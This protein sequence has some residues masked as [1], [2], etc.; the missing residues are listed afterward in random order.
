MTVEWRKAILGFTPVCTMAKELAVAKSFPTSL[1]STEPPVS[2]LHYNW[3]MFHL[4]WS[5]P[6]NVTSR[7]VRAESV[8]LIFHLR[9]FSESGT[10][11]P[12]PGWPDWEIENLRMRIILPWTVTIQCNGLRGTCCCW[13]YIVVRKDIRD[14]LATMKELFVSFRFIVKPS[15]DNLR[16]ITIFQNK[17]FILNHYWNWK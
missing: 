3:G 15:S 10:I 7:N 14:P 2:N 5:S 6:A 11:S 9:M 13:A 1:Q 4:G 16:L 8:C 12:G 17:L